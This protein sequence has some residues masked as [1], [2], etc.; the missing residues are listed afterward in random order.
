[1]KKIEY[2]P[3]DEQKTR[4]HFWNY[5]EGNL[6]FSKANRDVTIKLYY[7]KRLDVIGEDT[8]IPIESSIDF[9]SA[10]TASLAAKFIGG[11]KVLSDEIQLEA[12]VALER[13]KKRISKG[14]QGF[15]T[16]RI[17]YWIEHRHGEHSDGF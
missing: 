7:I 17:P 6:F 16:R 1:M 2:L 12:D 14:N 9:L 11:N 3:S 10:R 5:R 8:Q 4:L 15:G 13:D